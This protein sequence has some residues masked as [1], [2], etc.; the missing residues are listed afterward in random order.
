MAKNK[1]QQISKNRKKDKKSLQDIVNAQATEDGVSYEVDSDGIS[2]IFDED[3]TMPSAVDDSINEDYDVITGSSKG[4]HYV[5]LVD[6]ISSEELT[7]LSNVVVSNVEADDESRSDWLDTLTNGFGLLGVEIEEKNEPFEGACSASHPLLLESGV[8]FQSKA[9]NELLPADGPVKGK[10]LGEVTEEKEMQALR[11]KN[12]MNYQLTEEMEEFYSDTE[13]LLLYL[14]IVGMGFKKIYYD[15][16]LERPVSDFV[17]ATDLIVPDTATDLRRTPRFTHKLFKTKYEFEADCSRGLYK[18]TDF[19]SNP[20][21]KEITEIDQRQLELVGQSFT[22]S[23]ED[24]GYQL[25]EHYLDICIDGI[26]KY[27]GKGDYELASPYII[28]VDANSNEVISVRRNWAKEDKKRRKMIPFVEYH[29]V[30]SFTFH[31]YGFLHLLGN[32]QLTLTTTLRSLV[33]AGQFANLQGGFKVKGV[34]IVDNTPI[35]PGEFRDIEGVNQDISKSIMP[36]PFKEPSNVLYMMLDF[37]DKKGQKFADQT[38]G[39]LADSTNYGPVG[40]TM[41]LLDA[42]AKF[43]SA[44]HK[45]LHKSLK[46]ELRKIAKINSKTFK[47]EGGYNATQ[48]EEYKIKRSD[49]DDK[50][51]IIP[52]SDPNISSSSHRM[53]KANSLLEMAIRNPAIHDMKEV[54]KHVYINMDYANYEKFFTDEEKSKAQGPLEDIIT[55]SQNKPIK[56]FEGQDHEA[57]VT[58]KT[59]FLQDPSTGAGPAMGIV[60]PILQANI[61]EHTVMMFAEQLKAQQEVSGEEAI[62]QAAQQVAKMNQQKAMEASQNQAQNAQ[63][64]A[65]LMLAQAELM[66]TQLQADKQKF[67][68]LHKIAELELKREKLDADVMKEI[69]R[70]DIDQQKIV[71]D[72][73]KKVDTKGIEIMAEG[74]KGEANRPS[75]T[76]K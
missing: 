1:E 20:S 7:R 17:F 34:R 54:Y 53:A 5:N 68:E 25:Y 47:E 12:H 39:V 67:E 71:S 37:I 73:A 22:P 57:H 9:S 36:L 15:S 41:A 50:I 76:Q 32:L 19:L 2:V 60:A 65:A 75:R 46:Q 13:R 38:D 23:D 16:Y 21:K 64:Q 8:K 72:Y 66:D 27:E 63:D 33:D 58:V 6:K 24:V 40:T 55:A 30:P 10:V 4:G 18:K 44:I 29:F 61:R 56:A 31:S 43:F 26:D 11:V 59:A 42:S 51:D 69:R 14:S 28:T 70:A 52:V 35:S 45:R 49:Y 48:S 74:L 62:G 3:D